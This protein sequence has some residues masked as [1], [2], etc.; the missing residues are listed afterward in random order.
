MFKETECQLGAHIWKGKQTSAYR[1]AFYTFRY[2]QSEILSES[3]I[4]NLT[5]WIITLYE[6]WGYNKH[7]PFMQ[8]LYL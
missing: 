6:G 7:L 8:L 2:R 5:F 4:N 3:T 1:L